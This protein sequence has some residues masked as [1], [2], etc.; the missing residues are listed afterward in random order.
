MITE[1]KLSHSLQDLPLVRFFWKWLKSMHQ[2]RGHL[3]RTMENDPIMQEINTILSFDEKDE[4]W[5]AFFKG[6]DMAI[7]KSENILQCLR[8]FDL[9]RTYMKKK[10]FVITLQHYHCKLLYV[11]LMESSYKDNVESTEWN[12]AR[13]QRFKNLQSN[14]SWYSVDRH[15]IIGLAVIMYIERVWN[16]KKEPI[17]IVLDP[18]RKVVN[19]NALHMLWIWGSLAFPFTSAREAKLWK[20]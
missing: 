1:E 3:G 14:M 8:D 7:T 16:F 17:A 19:N 20:Q 11:Q 12:E 4:G 15:S 18:Q 5:A 10:E 9:W 13:H 2:S 6:S